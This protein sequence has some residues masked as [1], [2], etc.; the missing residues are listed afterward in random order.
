MMIKSIGFN[1]CSSWMQLIWEKV[2]ITWWGLGGDA[3][4]MSSDGAT[5]GAKGHG[6]LVTFKR[7]YFGLHHKIWQFDTI[8]TI[9]K[10][11]FKHS[12]ILYKLSTHIHP[13][14]SISCWISVVSWDAQPSSWVKCP[15]HAMGQNVRDPFIFAGQFNFGLQRYIICIWSGSIYTWGQ[16]LWVNDGFRLP[17]IDGSSSPCQD[18]DFMV[19][20]SLD[21]T[22]LFLRNLVSH[23]GI[24]TIFMLL[25]QQGGGNAACGTGRGAFIGA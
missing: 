6:P 15:M 3:G 17:A 25:W 20:I 18:L 10:H 14:L 22:P 13:M 9:W 2:A 4:E 7:G 5:C 24:S 21:W 8:R 12:W 16:C 23:H 1:R 11:V 19:L